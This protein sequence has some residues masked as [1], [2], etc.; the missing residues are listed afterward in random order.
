[1]KRYHIMI[2]AGTEFTRDCHLYKFRV[3]TSEQDRRAHLVVVRFAKENGYFID[4]WNLSN[5]EFVS[6]LAQSVGCQ[7]IQL[8]WV[9]IDVRDLARHISKYKT[10]PKKQPSNK[11][12]ILTLR[13]LTLIIPG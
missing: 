13:A 7:A 9:Y 8:K 5:R 11:N 1:M 10:A 2:E 3:G 4:E 6:K 12:E